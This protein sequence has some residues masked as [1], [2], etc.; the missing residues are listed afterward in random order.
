MLR[1]F[2]FAGAALCAFSVSPLAAEAV[3]KLD[4]RIAM[5]GDSGWDYINVD[6]PS[7]RLYLTR[8]QRVDVLDLET[9]KII[10]SIPGT[11]GV[12]GV[13]IA[14]DLGKG[15]ASNGMSGTVTVFDLQTL[16]VAK[17]IP[18]G[19][20]PDAILYDQPSGQVFVFNGRSRSA[21][22][23][24]ARKGKV[25]ATIDLGARPEF[26]ANDGL[27][28]VFV[29]FEDKD[30]IAAI[31]TKTLKVRAV[32]PLNAKGPSGLAMDREHGLL[33]AVCDGK[34]MEVVDAASGS[35]TAEVAI[36]EHPDAATFD[37]G[38]E[39]AFSSNGDGTL[40]VAQE[41]SSTAFT[42]VDTVATQK[43]ARTLALDPSNHQIYLLCARYLSPTPEAADEAPKGASPT[44]KPMHQ[45]PR[46]EPGSV[47]L[48][49]LKKI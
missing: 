49:V 12:H 36:G 32:W 45:R 44:A 1:P 41:L 42:V 18:V 11:A 3:Y 37:P 10:G 35:V 5:P 39:L 14:P 31:D 48:L 15:Y 7:R 8:G 19:Q 20:G 34:K 16:K 24:D 6:A 2:L 27:H 25:S 4:H 17:P 9:E 23:I 40:T 26:A 21:S 13:A 38:T 46:I 28:T 29:N 30:S 47:E 22:V 33:F 43:G